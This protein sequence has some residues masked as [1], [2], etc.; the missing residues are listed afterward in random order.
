MF[1]DLVAELSRDIATL[2]HKKGAGARPRDLETW[3][4]IVSPGA[5][6]PLHFNR[7]S[8]FLLQFRGRKPVTVFEPWNPEVIEHAACGAYVA[9]EERRMG[10]LTSPRVRTWLCFQP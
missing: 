7:F 4:F 9:R 1:R 10:H 6:T 3:L 2:M 5:F 8:N